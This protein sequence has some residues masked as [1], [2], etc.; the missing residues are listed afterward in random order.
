M[1]AIGDRRSDDGSG[2]DDAARVAPTARATSGHIAAGIKRA[3]FVRRLRSAAEDGGLVLLDGP[4]NARM[5]G[6]PGEM[7]MPRGAAFVS[8]TFFCFA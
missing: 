8:M 2:R 5:A 3:H 6:G 7:R 1:N 4:R